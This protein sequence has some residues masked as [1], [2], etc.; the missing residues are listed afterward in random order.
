MQD[1]STKEREHQD[2]APHT[3]SVSQP[4]QPAL[5]TPSNALADAA[6]AAGAATQA[7]VKQHNAHTDNAAGEQGKR[8]CAR[9]CF[10]S[11]VRTEPGWKGELLARA[12]ELAHT[13]TDCLRC[14]EAYSSQF[15]EAFDL[16]SARP[17]AAF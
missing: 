6:H 13:S 4:E 2:R 16:G 9:V 5:A 10:M 15:S 7:R 8:E 17:S 12:L 14:A 11:A 3:P 1:G